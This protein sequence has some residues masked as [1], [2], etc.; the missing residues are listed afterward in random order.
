MLF[1]RRS[2]DVY[3]C[4]TN[5]RCGPEVGERANLKEGE[6]NQ[7]SRVCGHCNKLRSFKLTFIEI[8]GKE[9]VETIVPQIDPDGEIANY[10]K[11]KSA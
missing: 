7:A 1:D 3:F 4:L 9:A 11:E 8:N 6:R 10:L 2:F 5:R